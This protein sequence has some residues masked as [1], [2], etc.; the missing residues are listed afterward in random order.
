M[1]AKSENP[2]LSLQELERI[3]LFIDVTRDPGHPSKRDA[4][5]FYQINIVVA[6]RSGIRK[7]VEHFSRFRYF[8]DAN[9]EFEKYL[10]KEIDKIRDLFSLCSQHPGI[11]FFSFYLKKINYV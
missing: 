3:F 11:L 10:P 8:C 2:F 6:A 5:S 1:N 9:K 7:I 4:S